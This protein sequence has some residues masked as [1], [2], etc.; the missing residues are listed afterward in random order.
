MNVGD[1]V[2]DI[3]SSEGSSRVGG[4]DFDRAVMDYVVDELRNRHRWTGQLSP[5]VDE[6]I[7]R[8]SERAKRDLGRRESTT[9]LLQDFD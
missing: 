9:I 1:G 4:L 2:A 6:N 5:A 7:R 8:E 3:Y